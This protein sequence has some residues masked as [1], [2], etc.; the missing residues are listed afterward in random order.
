MS[1]PGPDTAGTAA[2]PARALDALPGPG[3]LPVL[4]NVLQLELPRLHQQL[5][6]WAAQYGAIYRLQI[7]RQRFVCIADPDLIGAILRLRPEHWRRVRRLEQI[8]RE[9]GANG[10]FSAEGASWSRQRRMVMAAFDPGHLKRFFPRQVLI[11]ER[12]L[13]RWQRAADSGLALELQPELMRYSVDTVA[14]LALGVDVD[15]IEEQQ[16]PLQRHLDTVLPVVFRRLNAPLPYWRWIRLPADRDF[17][18][19]LAQMHRIMREMIDSAR[20][21]MRAAPSL[22]EHPTNLLEAMLAVRDTDGDALSEEELVG[23]VFTI[24]LAGED[25]TAN[26]LA[27]TLWLLHEDRDCWLRLVDEADHVLGDQD[28]PRSFDALREFAWLAACVD[29]SMRLRP[30]APLIY[31]ETQRDTALGGL[32]IPRGTGAILLMR[33]AA[34]DAGRLP[35]AGSFDPQRRLDRGSSQRASLNHV[36]RPFGGGPRLCPGRYLALLETKMLLSMLARNFE[37]VD[38]ATASGGAPP[39]RMAFTM[40][41]EGLRMRLARRLH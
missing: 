9:I 16:D 30:V 2:H 3:A 31:L 35:D 10:V 40:H 24:L 29:E 5:E 1:S 32:A 21:R 22:A 11:T 23:N 27:W 37:L 17:D 12:L 39:E 20:K 36:T 28:M 41:P 6:D 26:T 25:T 4:G 8:A 14:G 38:V 15:T 33:F 7:G 19:H 18:R 13:A 34:I